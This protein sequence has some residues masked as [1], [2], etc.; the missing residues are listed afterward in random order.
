MMMICMKVL[1]MA[2]R[3]WFLLLSLGIA[4]TSVVHR[5]D[6]SIDEPVRFQSIGQCWKQERVLTTFF[7]RPL[8]AADVAQ[9]AV[10]ML[11]QPDRIS[12]KALDIV[13]TGT[14]MNPYRLS[15][16]RHC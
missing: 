9:A 7:N 12:V 14:L 1:L 5:L 16:R 8:Q 13:P 6:H 3:K 15:V 10:Y 2:S 11:S 4:P